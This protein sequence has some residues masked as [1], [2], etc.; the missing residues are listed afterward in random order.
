MVLLKFFSMNRKYW[1]LLVMV[2]MCTGRT[3]CAQTSSTDSLSLKS[4]IQKVMADYPSIK[5]AQESLTEADA[6]INLSHAGY[7]PDIDVTGNF[8]YIDPVSEISFS[9]F[10]TFS[11]VPKDNWN[12]ALNVR[13]TLW[14]FGRTDKNV[15]LENRN[16]ELS[17]QSVAQTKQKISSVVIAH[18]FAILYLQEAIA[19][20][21]EELENLNAHLDFVKKKMETGSSTDYEILSTEVKISSI[22]SQKLDLEASQ[23]VHCAAMNSLLGLPQATPLVVKNEQTYDMAGLSEDSLMNYAFANRNEMIMVKKKAEIADLRVKIAHNQYYPS[24]TAN[25]SGGWKNGYTPDKEQLRANYV[26]GVGVRIP[27]FDASKTKY[28]VAIARTAVE[29]NNF[30]AEVTRRNIS[31]EVVENEINMRNAQKK[32]KQF[33]LQYAQAQRAFDMAQ[34]KFKAGTITNLDLLDATTTLSES[35]LL[36]LKSNID[37]AASIYRLRESVGMKLYE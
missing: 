17:E 33:R 14:D 21:D 2:L 32:V 35:R 1:A 6:R 11:F 34:T 22:E 31:N 15:L 13:Q 12:F 25:L 23:K 27:I 8:S 10:G 5:Q 7:L 9:G 29:A 36:L 24:L 26:A 18:Y 3:V 37:Y 20:K 16:K 28:N 4:I 19:I 30:E